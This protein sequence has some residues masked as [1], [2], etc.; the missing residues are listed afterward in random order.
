MKERVQIWTPEDCK[1]RMLNDFEKGLEKGTTTHNID[2]DKCWTWRL[3]EFNIWTG[4]Q[5]EGKALD[6]M[7]KI[8][9][10]TG[11]VLLKDIKVNDVVYDE[12][13]EQC[14]VVNVTD[15]MNNR[16][17][18]KITFSDGATIIA[19]EDHQWMID[20]KASRDSQKRQNKRGV[21]K[22]RGTDQRHKCIKSQILTTKELKELLESKMSPSVRLPKGVKNKEKELIID[23]YI[24]GLWLGDGNKN[25]GLL[26]TNDKEIV[27]YIVNQGYTVNNTKHQHYYISGL[28]QQL[29]MYNLI[30]N[31]HIPDIYLNASFEQR[32]ELARGLMDSDGYSDKLSRCELVTVKENLAFEVKQLL[33]SLGIKIY[34]T[35]DDAKLYGKFIS[36]RYRLRFKTTLPIFNLGR[37]L[38][39]Q[40]LKPKT[41]N[42]CRIIKSI[43]S[44]PSVPVKCIEVD[45]K[46]HLFLC[47]ENYIPTHNSLFIRQLALIKA[48]EDNWKFVFAAP[49]DFP[50]HEFFD[51]MIHTIAGNSTDKDN[52]SCIN[53][54]QYLEALELIKNKFFFVYLQPPNNGLKE[55]FTEF[56]KLIDEN[57]E[58]KGCILDPYLK[59]ARPA[60]FERDDIYGG[61][62][63]TLCSHFAR[64]ENVSVHLVMHQLTPK[65]SE[66]GFYPK[67]NVYQ[68]KSGGSFADG[69]DNVLSVWRPTYAK[70]K[71]SSDVLFSSQKIKKQKLVG[72]PQDLK[73]TFDR[74]SNRYRIN[75]EDMFDFSR[76]LKTS[77]WEE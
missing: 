22:K 21:I 50:P 35:I 1:E 5:N 43:E 75:G 14:N 17:C 58:I 3:R 66:N 72:I 57:P 69:A 18:Y 71:I 63:T 33:S 26:T 64:E 76:F 74:R 62:V 53:K 19:D 59:F 7:T 6:I 34:L 40:A 52:I 55:T 20:T 49:E 41:K 60:N 51:D 37:K 31:K 77:K 4:Y 54:S 9:T 11:L 30:G 23:P 10:P 73:I 68:I 12:N 47:T 48:L 36:K 39:R 61:Y 67:P 27:N 38:Q 70:D 29:R 46:S 13:G 16:P 45:S 56:K 2:L 42:N 15:I 65:L 24:L 32:L 8:P 25:D 44:M 28:K